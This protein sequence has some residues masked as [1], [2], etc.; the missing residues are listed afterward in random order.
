M[1]AQGSKQRDG[2]AVPY[3][4]RIASLRRGKA[5]VSVATRRLASPR[6]YFAWVDIVIWL[7]TV[8]RAF[9]SAALYVLYVADSCIVNPEII[10][11]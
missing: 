6:L 4:V 5:R 2:G 7:G 9:P 11:K 1:G 3:K 10:F 8:P